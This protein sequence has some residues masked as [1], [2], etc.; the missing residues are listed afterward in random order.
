MEA[1]KKREILERLKLKGRIFSSDFESL[2]QEL[3]TSLEDEILRKK[4]ALKQL[5]AEK[6][7]LQTVLHNLRIA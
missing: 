6:E 3:E 7:E 1:N 5:L 4:K 2:E